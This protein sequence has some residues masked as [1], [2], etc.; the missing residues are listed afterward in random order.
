[1]LA[2]QVIASGSWRAERGSPQFSPALNAVNVDCSPAMCVESAAGLFSELDQAHAL[3]GL[4]SASR[5]SYRV[6]Q[7]NFPKVVATDKS[8][9]TTIILDV[10]MQT[11]ERVVAGPLAARYALQ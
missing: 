6:E 7:W 4:F 11:A 1:V 9:L 3:R 8:T 2:D 10:R 5:R